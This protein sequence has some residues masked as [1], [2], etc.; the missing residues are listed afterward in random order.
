MMKGLSRVFFQYMVMAVVISF[1]SIILSGTPYAQDMEKL[2][3][4]EMPSD[5]KKQEGLPPSPPPEVSPDKGSALLVTNL[6]GL[7][8]VNSP[9]KIVPKGL[10][11]RGIVV[12]G[13]QEQEF[14]QQMNEYLGKPLTMDGLNEIL[15][16]VVLYFRATDRPV[17]DIYAPEQDISTGTIQIVVL[18][19]SLGKVRTEGNKWFSDGLL[20]GKIRVKPGEVI[21]GSRLLDDLNWIN[22]NP[23]RRTDLIFTRG[24][25][26]GETDIILTTKER[27]PVRVFAGYEDSGTELTGN[28]RILAGFNWGN[29]FGADHQLN[30][31]F[32][33]N[34]DI[35]RFSAHSVSY[36]APLPWRHTLTIFGAFDE[37]KPDI[38][39]FD[40]KG[41]ST[42][43]YGR[44][45]IPLQSSGGYTHNTQVAVDFKSTDNSLDFS[46]IPI[47][48]KKTQVFQFIAGYSGMLPD[49]KGSTAFTGSLCYS[50][51]D[52]MT[53]NK[54]SSFNDLTLGAKARYTY[55]QINAERLT[56]L[57]ADVTWDLKTNFQFA[58]GTLLGS[59]RMGFG[60]YNTVRGYDERVVNGDGGYLVVNELRTQGIQ[61]NRIANTQHQLGTLQLIA[62]Y[63]YGYATYHDTSDNIGLSSMG[64]G[65]RYT[66][67]T[68]LSARFDYGWQLKDLNDGSKENSRAHIGVI[69]AF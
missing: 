13:Y 25:K 57:P 11:Q 28:D 17:V 7:V 21:Y 32:T 43:V 24:D 37:S 64:L 29:A 36:Q 18:E 19:G 5:G 52:L 31:Q 9:D 69:G 42:E 40:S 34:S 39:G 20:T 60:G 47:F 45:G 46:N 62:F 27:F 4:K 53:Y 14:F 2:T 12:D 63:D 55:I 8:F 61:L 49:T 38:E 23:F 1:S 3:P 10:S 35:N 16:K 66:L 65:L 67:G 6:V 33:C 48:D 41:K 56:T 54:D 68:Y 15:K 26:T 58:S 59:E 22:A 44:Y 51:G 50:P 30:Y